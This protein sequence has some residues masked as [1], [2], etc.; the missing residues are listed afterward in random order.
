MTGIDM[1]PPAIKRNQT[2]IAN[3][4]RF[5]RHRPKPKPSFEEWLE[6]LDKGSEKDSKQG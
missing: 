1:W 6:S 3:L 5:Y 2:H 4:K